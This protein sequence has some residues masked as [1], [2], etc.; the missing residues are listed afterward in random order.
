LSHVD[1]KSLK[2]KIFLRYVGNFQE[3]HNVGCSKKGIRFLFKKNHF[4]F[5][6]DHFVLTGLWQYKKTFLK[7]FAKKLSFSSLD[8][9]CGLQQNTTVAWH[10]AK[11]KGNTLFFSSVVYK[12]MPKGFVCPFSNFWHFFAF[13]VQAT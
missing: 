3:C 9:F 12:M 11:R 6:L 5:F 13:F 2:K 10:V 7:C 4:C 1:P 8:L